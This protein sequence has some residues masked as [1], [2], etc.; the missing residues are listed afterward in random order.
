MAIAVIQGENIDTGVPEVFKTS[1][2][3][4]VTTLSYEVNRA[5]VV[6][7][8]SSTPTAVFSFDAGSGQ[9]VSYLLVTVNAPDDIVAGTRLKTSFVD[10]K[11]VGP[12]T[13][14][15][16]TSA[17]PITRLDIV[18]IASADNDSGGTTTTAST[19]AEYRDSMQTFEFGSSSVVKTATITA[20]ALRASS[21]Y[22]DVMVEGKSHA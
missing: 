7:T 18:A 16:I 5:S 2:G 13:V 15:T 22:C 6:P 1:S 21:R 19:V 4:G 17:D 10:T 20:L 11:I 9:T 3:L 8:I 14:L 12:D